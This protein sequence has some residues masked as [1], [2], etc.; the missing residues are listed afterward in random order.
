M[1]DKRQKATKVKCK[2]DESLMKQSKFD[3]EERQIEQICIG[4][5]ITTG[6]IV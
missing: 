2:R 5:P 1:T 3:Q 6:F 4:N